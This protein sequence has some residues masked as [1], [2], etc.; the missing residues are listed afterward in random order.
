M[1]ERI[2]NEF[3]KLVEEAGEE[4]EGQSIKNVLREKQKRWKEE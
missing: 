3:W 4:G 2:E 1:K